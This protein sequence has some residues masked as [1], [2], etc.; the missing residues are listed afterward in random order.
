MLDGR[1]PRPRSKNAPVL[2]QVQ[3]GPQ[4][5]LALKVLR[6]YSIFA[7]EHVIGGHDRYR[8]MINTLEQ[9]YVLPRRT[10]EQQY[11]GLRVLAKLRVRRVSGRR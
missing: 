9:Q 5:P 8:N 3:D 10:P 11:P 2:K 4:T 6:F 7:P 1:L